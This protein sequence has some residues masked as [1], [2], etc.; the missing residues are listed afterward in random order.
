MTYEL[1]AIRYATNPR[2]QVRDN[3][4]VAPG[5]IHDGP[6]PMDFF[7]W[8]AVRDGQAILI[9]SG[10]D[11]ETCTKRGHDFLRCPTEGLAALG[12][13]P[14]N[15]TG[16]ISTHLHW[17]HAGN[18]E[19]FPR[20]RFH[21][22][23]CE[24]QHAVGPCMCRPFLRRAYDVEQVVSFVRLVHGER[25]TFHEGESEVAPGITVR[26][27]GGHAPGLQVVRVHTKRG[28]VVLASDAMHFFANAETGVPFP[29]VVNVE[30]YLAAQAMLPSLGESKQHVIPGHDPKVMALY[31]AIA[32][33]VIR[34]DVAPA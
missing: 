28:W 15:V 12:V 20:A 18:F 13:K 21:A 25:V 34:L 6:M 11:R 33:D 8:A 4:M 1:Y 16:I 31:P 10:A 22:Q 26:H 23:A 24:I 2:R 30:D 19:K 7:V 9:D 17:D 3:F 14:E 5:D 29:V 27:V 32:P